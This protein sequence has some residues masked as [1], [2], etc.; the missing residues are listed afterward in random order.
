MLEKNESMLRPTQQK[1]VLVSI[2][3]YYVCL[4]LLI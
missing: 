2:Q 1:A 4:F 3:V